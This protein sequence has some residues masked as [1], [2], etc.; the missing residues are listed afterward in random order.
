M[1]TT[2]TRFARRAIRMAVIA[3]LGASTAFSSAVQ[4]AE[5]E[6]AQLQ[7]VEVTGTRIKRL[8]VEGP[9]PVITITA[10]DIRYSGHTSLS[11]VLRDSSFNSFGS[12]Q[13]G[14]GFSGGAQGASQVNL[15]GVGAQYTLVLVN[16]RRL[17]NSPAFSGDQQN[18]NNIPMAAVE[19]V[20]ILRDGASAIYGSDAIGGVINV[21]LKSDYEGLVVGGQA[22]R[23]SDEGGDD[24][25]FYA[26]MGI[27]GERGHMLVSYENYVRDIILAASRP[28]LLGPED[29]TTPEGV[30]EAAQLGLISPTGFPG[31]YRRLD[32]DGNLF[33]VGDPRRDWEAG[34]GCPDTF[35]SDANFPRSGVVDAADFGLGSGEVCGYNF[36]AIA[37]NTAAMNRDNLAVMGEYDVNGNVTAFVRSVYAR[38]KSFGR[39]APTPST[40]SAIVA[41]DAAYNPTLGEVSATEGYDLAV[42]IRFDPLGPRDTFVYDYMQDI[43][44]GLIGQADWFGGAEW[45]VAVGNSRNK[46]DGFGYNYVIVPLLQRAVTAGLNPFDYDA[47]AAASSTF[48]VT[49]TN[50]NYYRDR[51]ADARLS[52]DIAEIGGRPVGFVAGGEYHDLS[53]V[54]VTDQQSQAG[55]VVG[56]A[57]ATSGGTRTWHAGYF[58]TLLPVTDT[59]EINLAGRFDTYSDFGNES[60]PKLS[61]AWRPTDTLLLRANIGEG[62]KAPN[63]DQL[64][65]APSQSFNAG[66]DRRECA[67]LGIDPF[68]TECANVQRETFLPSN[69]NLEPETAS[70]WTFGG[71]WNPVDAFSIGLDYYN[72]EIDNQIRRLTT[73][74]VLDAEY[75]CTIENRTEFCDTSFW[76]SV[77]RSNVGGIIVTRPLANTAAISTDGIDMDIT[78]GFDTGFGRISTEFGIS[79]I[80]TFETEAVPGS[81][82]VDN[83]TYR[84]FPDLRANLSLLWNFADFNAAIIGNYTDGWQDCL[85]RVAAADPESPECEANTPISSFTTWNVQAGYEMPWDARI[86]VG[87]RNVF[88]RTAELQADG[89]IDATHTSG[90]YGRTLYASFEQRF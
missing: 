70:Q 7:R 13:G 25:L 40:V 5:E 36:A 81:G 54:S 86:S 16:G 75:R 51:F 15:R 68:S 32:A 79:K 11:D 17:S 27:S 6:A 85:A 47:V 10:D 49:I 38:A 23:P 8:D 88:D 4:A 12:F 87:V 53:Y 21:I 67:N 60:S 90:L 52:W 50:D 3:G 78:Y 22:S 34:P 29:L 43:Q 77:N 41:A 39:F 61:I 59:V 72:I 62:F 20:E 31:R 58:E 84:G 55:Q 1:K 57:G 80:F 82:L 44:G 19:R 66:R 74:D 63:M 35:G 45:E 18:V 48:A 24:E 37:G 76:G 14:S 46:Q 26:L 28:G 89:A 69:L 33:A 56:S 73:Q 9:Q 2:S 42:N 83:I 64:Y 30:T 65:S 71:V